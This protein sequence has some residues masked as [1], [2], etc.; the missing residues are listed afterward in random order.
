MG[1]ALLAAALFFGLLFGF[2][3]YGR[4]EKWSA[5]TRWGGGFIIAA[6][7]VG[8][9][10]LRFSSESSGTVIGAESVSNVQEAKQF[11]LG[12]WTFTEP[13]SPNDP[14]IGQWEKWIVKDDE[15]VDVYTAY[16]TADDWGKPDTKVYEILTSKYT[17][18]GKR[19]YY[20]HLKGM[21]VSASILNDDLIGLKISASPA[22]PMRR[23]DRNPFSK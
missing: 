12:T 14:Y 4:R 7:I 15:T 3:Y 16:P 22:V 19:F 20:L 10:A 5:V 8:V 17:D 21:V 11:L 6:L 9:A 2:A 1:L 18:T 23:G 13:L